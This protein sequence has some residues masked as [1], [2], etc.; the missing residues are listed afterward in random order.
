MVGSRREAGTVA[1]EIAER[2]NLS[3]ND[4]VALTDDA[5]VR[6]RIARRKKSTRVSVVILV[7]SPNGRGL[8]A[9]SE[10]IARIAPD[11]VV[12]A[13]PATAKSSDV[14]RWCRE[15]GV[16]ALA[17]RHWDLTETPADLISALPVLSVDGAEMSTLRWVSLLLSTYLERSE[18]A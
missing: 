17:L 13:V 10:S 16:T 2:L 9:A 15:L 5:A 1:Q 12:G 14:D 11:Y 4:V 8:A 6:R 18:Q 7:A 3:E